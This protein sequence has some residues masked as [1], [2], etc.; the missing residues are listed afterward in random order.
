MSARLLM[1]A[2]WALQAENRVEFH[3]VMGD[4]AAAEGRR[5]RW[6]SQAHEREQAAAIALSK[7]NQQVSNA[8]AFAAVRARRDALAREYRAIAD[9]E[10]HVRLDHVTM[11]CPICLAALEAAGLKP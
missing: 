10:L 8:P 1:F 3:R 5:F 6:L 4:A 7:A 11:V 9:F 2:A